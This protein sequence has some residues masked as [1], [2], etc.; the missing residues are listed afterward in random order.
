MSNYPKD[1]SGERFGRL[2]AIKTTPEPEGLKEI[3]SKR[4]TFWLCICDCGKEKLVGRNSLTAK[5][6][7]KSCGCLVNEVKHLRKGMKYNKVNNKTIEGVPYYKAR[8]YGIWNAMKYRC[9]SPKSPSYKNYGKK[10][11]IVCDRWLVFS[12][13]KEDMFE[14]FL[15]FEKEH[16]EGSATLD[17]ID[18][19]GN[20]EPL[21]CRW[22]TT[23]EQSRNK[24]NSIKPVINGIKYESLVDLAKE[25]NIPVGTLQYRYA[26]GKRGITLIERA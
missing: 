5:S 13:F 19:N 9:M 3:K 24:K 2:T 14:L 22:A 1:L 11:I 25:Y 10:G 8:I 21:N 18:S 6:G 12:N 26:N 7:T 15:Q 17:R 4:R 23:H 16:G 20:Y